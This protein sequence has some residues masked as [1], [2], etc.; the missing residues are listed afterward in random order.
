MVLPPWRGEQVQYRIP[1][2]LDCIMSGGTHTS[3]SVLG[4]SQVRCVRTQTMCRAGP[5]PA[6][7]LTYVRVCVGYVVL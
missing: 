2:P 4:G 6:T 3:C 7:V 5:G 1:V